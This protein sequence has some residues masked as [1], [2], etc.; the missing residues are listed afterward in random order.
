MGRL[1]LPQE[2]ALQFAQLAELNETGTFCGEFRRKNHLD[3][4]DESTGTVTP[5]EEILPP[6]KARE[7]DS[8]ELWKVENT[9][10]P[11]LSCSDTVTNM[12][13][14]DHVECHRFWT[15]DRNT[16]L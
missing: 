7:L 11:L 3:Q 6:G 12:I 1:Q 2:A 14:Y 16:E 10:I 5:R 8:H 4:D 9:G 15:G 13:I